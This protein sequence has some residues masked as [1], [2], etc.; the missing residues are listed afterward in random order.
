MISTLS[1]CRRIAWCCFLISYSVW[2]GSRLPITYIHLK[3]LDGTQFLTTFISGVRNL[4]GPREIEIYA[5]LHSL[6][7]KW[8]FVVNHAEKPAD[9]PDQPGSRRKGKFIRFGDNVKPVSVRCYKDFIDRGER[10]PACG[11]PGKIPGMIRMQGPSAIWPAAERKFF[12]DITYPRKGFISA[13]AYCLLLS[14]YRLI[15]ALG[16]ISFIFRFR[17]KGTYILQQ[18]RPEQFRKFSHILTR[19]L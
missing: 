17:M 11:L 8:I 13:D 2:E 1:D 14:T 5:R 3:A 6:S 9:K 10:I 12:R 7:D 16:L 15:Y 4:Y 19:R 18:G